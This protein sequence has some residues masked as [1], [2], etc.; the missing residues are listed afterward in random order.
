MLDCCQAIEVPGGE[1]NRFN[2]K[3]LPASVSSF[4]IDTFEVTVGRF[5]SF[6][7]AWPGS[8]PHVGDGA[9]PKNAGSGWKA[10]WDKFLPESK[11]AFSELLTCP[12]NPSK[13][14]TWTTTAGANERM[15]ISC[16]SWYE[17]F[18]FCA[19]D[20][21]RLPLEVEWLYSAVGGDE[22][23]STCLCENTSS[24]PPAHDCCNASRATWMGM[25]IRRGHSSS[26]VTVTKS[27]RS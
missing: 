15:P 5:R 17:A 1:F 14:A 2:D 13:T 26:S 8:K 6:V 10:A 4:R 18:A 12:G 25:N 27:Y 20:G 24:S 11:E 16:L 19:W 3:S 23:R 21:G 22:Q 7:D 9:H